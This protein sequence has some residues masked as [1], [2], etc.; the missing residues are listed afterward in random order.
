MLSNY[1]CAQMSNFKRLRLLGHTLRQG[2]DV[3]PVHFAQN[4]VIISPLLIKG[5]SSIAPERLY[6]ETS[7][8]S[9]KKIM[10]S[11]GVSMH[12]K[13]CIIFIGPQRTKVNGEYYVGLLRDKLI[14]ECHRLYPDDNYIFQQDSAP[15]H[16]YR[17]AQQFLQANTPDFIHSDAWSPNSPDLN[18]LDYYVYG[19]L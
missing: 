1:Y 3:R 17:L 18:P 16:H 7:R 12:G 19:T 15:S 6:R 8:F 14:P 5:K 10:V 2:Y 4:Y 11:A 13:T 9:K